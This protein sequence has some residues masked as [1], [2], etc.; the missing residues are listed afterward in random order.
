MKLKGVFLLLSVVLL[1]WG[2]GESWVEKPEKLIPENKMVDMLVDLHLA[3]AMYQ[4]K[5]NRLADRKM[6]IKSEDFY[7]SVLEK[8]HVPDSV[9]EKS[10][11][12][13]SCFPKDFEKIYASVLDR[14]SQMKEE[15]SGDD[16]QPLDVGN[17]D[18]R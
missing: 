11:I 6:K 4:I 14:V 7:Y 5:D 17:P 10:I 1:L 13:Y 8:H 16:P 12:Y 3:D 2:C 15:Y 18:R 9:F